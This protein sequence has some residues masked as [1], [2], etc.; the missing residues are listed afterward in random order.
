MIPIV[1]IRGISTTCFQDLIV[2]VATYWEREYAFIFAESLNVRFE[3]EP[4]RLLGA[5]IRTDKHTSLDLLCRYTGMELRQRSCADSG[6]ALAVVRS[7]LAEG[8]PVAIEFDAYW[9]PWGNKAAYQQVHSEHICLVTGF[10]ADGESLLC[11]DPTFSVG[12]ERLPLDHFMN[13]NRGGLITVSRH[14]PVEPEPLDLMR[15]IA[16]KYQES[17]NA[18]AIHAIANA[19]RGSASL[20]EEFEQV[21]DFWASPLFQKLDTIYYARHYLSETTAL[22]IQRGPE[23]SL[24]QPLDR[25][26]R[27]SDQ[28]TKDWDVVQK[29]LIK[30]YGV[31]AAKKEERAL[32][33]L[34]QR[35]AANAALEAELEQALGAMAEATRPVC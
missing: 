15:R 14:D 31:R 26:R 28:L 1:P 27:I 32:Q 10:D 22:L 7:E 17:R 23:P 29:L 18:E 20:A 24:G 2:S 5:A 6:E 16:A 4:G 30:H 12:Q 35:I 13:G 21:F 11:I 8:R 34:S 25:I 9:N 33:Q 19:I 3:P